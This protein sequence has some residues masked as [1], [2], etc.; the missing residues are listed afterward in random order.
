MLDPD[1]DITRYLTAKGAIR[2]PQWACYHSDLYVS[3]IFGKGIGIIG[4]AVGAPYAVLVAEEL[5]AS[6]CRMLI[7]VTSA[8]MLRPDLLKENA[9]YIIEKSVRGDGVSARYLLRDEVA[10]IG[11]QLNRRIHVTLRK[12]NIE[13]GTCTAWTTDAPFR[14]TRSAIEQALALGAECVE[15]ESA[16]LYAFA[17]A[18][19]REVVCIAHITNTMGKAGN[20]FEKGRDNGVISI[21]SVLKYIVR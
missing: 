15:M 20:D 12:S 8:G 9:L 21:L 11:G 10:S 6:G 14:E 19:K 16:G 13:V 17:K 2:M 5:F 1:G 7:S 18:C 4:C 3:S